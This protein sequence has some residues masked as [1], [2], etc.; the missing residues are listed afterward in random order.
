MT[1]DTKYYSH[2]GYF[3]AAIPW[4]VLKTDVQN[5]ANTFEFDDAD[6]LGE[7]ICVWMDSY[8]Q[9]KLRFDD[10]PSSSQLRDELGRVRKTI[11][12][13]TKLIRNLSPT[14][15]SQLSYL[16]SLP[17]QEVEDLL[18]GKSMILKTTIPMPYELDL[19]ACLAI[20]ETLAGRSSELEQFHAEAI[21][22]DSQNH[23]PSKTVS[24]LG[25]PAV[26]SIV[27]SSG[28]LWVENLNSDFRPHFLEG[29]GQNKAA[30]YLTEICKL[31]DPTITTSNMETSIKA[32]KKLTNS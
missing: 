2:A 29:K 19:F 14:A 11:D 8:N 24:Q 30:L 26:R 20:L 32:L 5:L 27:E 13:L 12:K 16:N 6:Y 15:Q 21:S 10:L 17:I 22:P 9:Y 23:R 31:I 28:K 18:L 4:R 7:R 3:M 25:S 1:N